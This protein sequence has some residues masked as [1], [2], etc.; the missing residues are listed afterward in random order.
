MARERGFALAAALAVLALLSALGAAALQSTTLEVQISAHDRDGR[1]ALCVATAALEEAGHF[2]ARGWG[3]LRPRG[4]AFPLEAELT[5]AWANPPGFSWSGQ[6]FAGLTL[7]DEAGG[8]FRLTGHSGDGA[9]P[10]ILAVAA[11]TPASGRFTVE[12]PPFAGTW[13]APEVVVADGAAVPDLAAWAVTAQANPNAFRHWLLWDLATGRSF[14]VQGSSGNPAGPE[15]RLRLTAGL[16]V[17]P[18]GTAFRLSYHPWLEALAGGSGAP[19]D[20]EPGT[21]STWDRGFAPL[22]QGS[23]TAR[24]VTSGAYRDTFELLARGVVLSGG[25]PMTRTAAARV[26]RPGRSDQRVGDWSVR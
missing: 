18:A 5:S 26:Y 8:E 3:T 14:K 21:P 17:P 13:T 9:T 16:A 12:R 15:V 23:V 6:R 7:V 20:E 4:A 1:G 19:G 25:R 11:G 2:A 24:R 10:V 22:G